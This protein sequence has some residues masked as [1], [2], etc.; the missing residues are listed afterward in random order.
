[1]RSTL[2]RTLAV[3]LGL[4]CVA[5]GIIGAFLPLLP[6]T[7][8]F[9]AAAACLAYASPRLESWLLSIDFIGEP[10]RAWRERGAIPLAAKIIASIGMGVGLLLCAVSPAGPLALGAA[11]VFLG[12]CAIF[13]WT[14]PG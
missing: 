10:V 2:F 3:L 4:V 11:A 14:R 13:I 12:L 8:F 9:I 7:V 6:S 1:M 5:L